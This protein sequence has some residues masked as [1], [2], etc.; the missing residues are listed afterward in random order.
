MQQYLFRG[1]RKDNNHWT[2]GS[3][4][5][6]VDVC[7]IHVYGTGTSHEVFKNTVG[8]CSGLEDKNGINIYDGD[9]VKYF[10]WSTYE[11][12]SY[13][14]YVDFRETEM[15]EGAGV[16]YWN[17]SELSWYVRP[18]DEL[19]VYNGSEKAVR[20]EELP[21]VY[22]G[23][24]MESIREWVGQYDASEEDLKQ[25]TCRDGIEVI[26]NIYD[27]NPTS[28]QAGN[29]YMQLDPN[30]QAAGQQEVTEQVAAQESASQDQA[31]E[32]TQN[33]EEGSTEG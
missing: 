10:Y 18:N 29:N 31:M 24:S 1:K 23:L 19:M 7:R 33:S 28:G 17:E 26:G 12:R 9:K 13:P 27:V 6:D 4:I 22:T 15:K 3:L 16:V 25:Y 32:A 20:L 5:L 14:E 11:Q 8:Q 30:Q 21:L 2:Y